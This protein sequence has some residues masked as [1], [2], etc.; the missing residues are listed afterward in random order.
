[1]LCMKRVAHTVVGVGV[2]A[3]AFA[4]W[5][6]FADLPLAFVENRGQTDGRVR[7]YA[8]GIRHAFHLTRDAAVLSF[9]E[10]PGSPHAPDTTRGVVL[11]LRF[12]GANPRVVLEGQHRAA[13]EVNYL[14]GND[15]SAWHTG[16]ARYS[17][18]R[19]RDLWRGVDMTLQG[20]SGALK[21]EFRVRPGARIEDIRQAYSGA[22][23]VAL[24]DGRGLLI[25]TAIG[26]LR[27]SPPVAYHEIGGTRVPVDA[28]Y[29][30]TSRQ[31]E[32]EYGFVVGSG[33]RRDL[34]LIVD[35][36]LDHATFLGGS[37]H[38]SRSRPTFLPPPAPSTERLP[39]VSW[40]SS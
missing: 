31:G 22:A 27:D 7:F 10:R 28:R 9:V 17:Q 8:Q 29:A 6:H 19:Y 23:G 37:S 25:H 36:G 5:T 3:L 4:A 30:L 20:Q 26:T 15:A 24:D 21:Y 11:A 32:T 34:E 39:A 38:E 1:M 12:V 33:Y 14:R 16:L 13:G 40:T 35:P 2:A 18:V